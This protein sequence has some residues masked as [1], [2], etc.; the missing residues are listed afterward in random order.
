MYISRY[1]DLLCYH[2]NLYKYSKIHRLNTL[3]HMVN[4][5]HWLHHHKNHQDKS[6]KEDL[7]YLLNK[8]NS[9]CIMLHIL[10]I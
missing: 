10:H 5:I 3:Y 4:T 7:F 9:Y 8:I 1:Q 6:T 2:Y